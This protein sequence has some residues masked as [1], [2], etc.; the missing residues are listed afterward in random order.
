M[1]QCYL[2]L[3]DFDAALES[4]RRALKL[5]PNLEGVRASVAY[6]ERAKK[7]KK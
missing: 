6:L 3:G 7:G 2:Q 4:F 1:G 5:N